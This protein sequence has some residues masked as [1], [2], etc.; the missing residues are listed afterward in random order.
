MKA[1]VYHGPKKVSVDNVPDAKIE[2]PT[3]VVIK[4]TTANI[5]GSDLHMYEGR[6]DVEKGKI[7]GHENLGEVVEVG[8]AVDSVKQGNKVV[9][10]FNI[11]CG[12]CA[13]CERGGGVGQLVEK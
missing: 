9:L 11:G 10:P 13:N 7:L 2:K 12:F 8:K 5:C 6:T 1:L 4:L 3:D